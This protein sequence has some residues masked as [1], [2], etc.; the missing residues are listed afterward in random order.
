MRRRKLLRWAV[1][2]LALAG[3]GVFLLWPR[4]ERVTREN[5]ARIRKGLSETEVQ[6]I[7]GPCHSFGSRPDGRYARAWFSSEDPPEWLVVSFDASGS[8]EQT[9]ARRAKESRWEIGWRRAISRVKHVAG[10]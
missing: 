9:S 6:A 2:G 5:F 3:F 10:P 1:A 4:P 8:V 7:L